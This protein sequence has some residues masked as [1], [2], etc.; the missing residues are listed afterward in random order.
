V[1]YIKVLGSLIYITIPKERTAGKLDIKANKGILVGFE[2]SNNFLVYLPNKNR[3]IS[4]R[5]VNIK[6]ELAYSKE[7]EENKEDYNSMLN[8]D[9]LNQNKLN[10][11]DDITPTSNNNKEASPSPMGEQR[12]QELEGDRS[13]SPIQ[14]QLEKETSPDSDIEE[15]IEVEVSN[16]DNNTQLSSSRYPARATRQEINYKGLGGLAT[17]YSLD[18]KAY[19]TAEPKIYKEPLAR[20]Y[21]DLLIKK[22]TV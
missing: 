22:P 14:A 13:R 15:T 1:D 9:L 10:I 18:P 4:S 8:F 5:D 6:E 12:E 20:H 19:I 7:L 16:E 3:V 21:K 11:E 2:S 17:I